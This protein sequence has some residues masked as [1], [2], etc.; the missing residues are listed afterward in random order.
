MYSRRVLSGDFA[1]VNK[2][3]LRDLVQGGYWNPTVK[4][5]LINDNGS[6]QN[7]DVVPQR[8]K[9]IYKTVWEIS[10]K[11]I[12]DMAAARGA[13]ICQ[14][15]S[16][17][18]FMGSPTTG[19]LTSMHF[20]AWKKGLKT[21]MYYLRTQPKAT[22]I[23]FTVDMAQIAASESAKTEKAAAVKEGGGVVVV[24]EGEL[25]KKKVMPVVLDDTE[26]CLSCG[27]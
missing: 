14:S 23:K 11:T 3:L 4:N 2:Y 1:V 5:Q 25:V 18:I 20:Y 13:F 27:A 26:G 24:A 6:V 19:K 7:I 17:N 22:A 10:Q 16:M 9:D 12:L 21:G 15:Q 8:L